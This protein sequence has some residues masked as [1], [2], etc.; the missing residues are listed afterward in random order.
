MQYF[1]GVDTYLH[2]ISMQKERNKNLMTLFS[3]A[4]TML[5]RINICILIYKSK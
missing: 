1:P 3:V 4:D 5:K 2:S